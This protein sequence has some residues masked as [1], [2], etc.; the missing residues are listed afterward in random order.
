MN[1]NNRFCYSAQCYQTARLIA[2]K[3][4]ITE[5]SYTV[6]FQSRLGKTPWI[7]PYTSDVIAQLANNGKKRLLVF[8]PAFVA[9]C[10]ETLYEIKEEYQESFKIL[11]GEEITLVEGLN[12]SPKWIASLAQ[13]STN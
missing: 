4:G 12:G 3:A 6:C 8:C 5:E 1:E 13:L 11:G 9:D 7:T 10:L 2:E